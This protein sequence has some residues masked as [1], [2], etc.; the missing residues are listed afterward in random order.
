[1]LSY[2]KPSPADTISSPAQAAQFVAN[3]FGNQSA[4][5]KMVAEVGGPS[6]DT[7]NAL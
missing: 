6:Q 2:W 5:L 7:L 1:M 3:V 4:F